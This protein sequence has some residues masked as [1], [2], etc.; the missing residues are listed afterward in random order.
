MYVGGI[1]VNASGV[2]LPTR[3]IDYRGI[4]EV[5]PKGIVISE[6]QPNIADSGQGEDMFVVGSAY[7]LRAEGLGFVIYFLVGD[8][9]GAPGSPHFIEPLGEFTI[10]A[11]FT[12]KFS[13]H[14]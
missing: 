3:I 8:Y 13:T 7:G 1:F 14:D 11:E 5:I 6:Q 10:P 2:Y 12:E 9:A 4:S